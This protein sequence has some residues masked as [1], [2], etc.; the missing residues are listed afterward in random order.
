MKHISSLLTHW[1]GKNCTTDEERY[2]ILLKKILAP[3]ELLF[4]Y[5]PIPFS[6]KYGGLRTKNVW[7]AEMVC[8]T[9]MPLS[10]S[11]EHCKKYSRFGV[12]FRKA[13]LANCLVCPVAYTLN[14][15]ISEAYSFLYQTA[16][17]LKHVTDG[18]TMQE[19]QHAGKQFSYD[20]YMQKLHHFLLWVQDHSP[21]EFPYQE[22][23]LLA[24]PEQAAF[25]DDKGS[26]YYEREWRAIYR[27]GDRFVWV[28]THDG[29]AYFRFHESS[30]QYVICPDAF[31]ERAKQDVNAMFEHSCRPD[32]LPFE[33]L[34]TGLWDF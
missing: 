20:M 29:K 25:F 30:V 15:F 12:A 7:G 8:F 2:D 16:L 21:A 14:P 1:V 18:A 28:S 32:V 26:Y 23:T 11:E 9:D 6:S 27:P 3:R 33:N 17:G 19:G 10:M 4:S 24:S 31:F 34:V 22:G 13:P 5:N